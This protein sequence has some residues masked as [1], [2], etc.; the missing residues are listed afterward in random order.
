MSD[1]REIWIEGKWTPSPGSETIQ[2]VNPNSGET[3]G[4]LFPVSNW[5]VCDRALDAATQAFATLELAPRSSIAAFLNS[6][7]DAIDANAQELAEMASLETGLPLSPRLKDV[8]LPRTSNQLRLAAKA[9]ENP[10]WAEATIDTAAGIRSCRRA[11]GPVVV[12]GPNNFPLAFNGISGGDFAAAIAAGNPVIV[13]SHPAHPNTTYMLAQLAAAALKK[14]E[15]PAATVQLIYHMPT[16]V[17]LQLFS[18]RRVGAVAFTGSKKAGLSIKEACDQ[19]GTPVYLEMSSVNPVLML[20]GAIAQRG[21]EIAAEL[22]GSCV[23]GCGQFCTNPGLILLT[24]SPATQEFVT[25]LTQ[26]FA[27][28]STG[29]MLTEGVMQH[30]EA[31]VSEVKKAG[32]ELL[33]GGQL[34]SEQAPYSYPATL[35]KITG[36]QFLSQ[37]EKMQTEMFGPVSLIVIA[38]DVLEL[39]IIIDQLE[40]NLTGTIY[41]ATDGMDDNVYSQLAPKLLRR[42]GRLL[43]DKMPTGVAVSAAMNHGGPFPSTGHPGFTAVGIPASLKRFSAL[44]C[45]DAVRPERLPGL[46]ADAAVSKDTWRMID[47]RWTNLAVNSDA[48]NG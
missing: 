7:A 35:L 21:D 46:L 4:S 10:T 18:D 43:N 40:G 36:S 31:A 47:G 42:V 14:S 22:T 37:P 15:L 41:S 44:K 17:G 29:T 3:V 24:N 20:P 34:K 1:S 48:A 13:K 23:M 30:V 6:Y 26:R 45:Y 16:D 12:I 8:E 25:N 39:E 5:E 38:E 33:A 2:A 19:V 9:C 11:I 32:A 28:T 27:E